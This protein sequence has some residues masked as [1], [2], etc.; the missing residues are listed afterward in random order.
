[1]P[2]LW[3]ARAFCR[4]VEKI[5]SIPK[6]NFH[7]VLSHVPQYHVHMAMGTAPLPPAACSMHQPL[8]PRTLDIP[9]RHLED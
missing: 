9:A 4:I 2:V 1:M 5:F 7:P 6:A 8:A 3:W